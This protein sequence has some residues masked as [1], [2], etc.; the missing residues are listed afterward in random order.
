MCH[1]EGL[2][3][4]VYS[5]PSHNVQFDHIYSKHFVNSSDFYKKKFVMKREIL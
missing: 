3:S 2:R 1:K 4:P 5:F